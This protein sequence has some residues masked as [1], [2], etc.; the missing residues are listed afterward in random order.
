ME[1]ERVVAE[2]Q[3]LS[4]VLEKLRRE[5]SVCA[6]AQA[7]AE[8]DEQYNRILAERESVEAAERTATEERC[9]A[10]QHRNDQHRQQ[11]ERHEK[12]TAIAIA[13][14]QSAAEKHAVAL[15][16]LQAAEQRRITAELIAMQAMQEKQKVA[17]QREQTNLSVAQALAE[18][19]AIEQEQLSMAQEELVALR[20]CQD[21]IRKAAESRRQQL[22]LAKDRQA[23]AASIATAEHHRL[24]TQ[25]KAISGEPSPIRQ[26][27][28]DEALD[29]AKN[30]I[31]RL[32]R[33]GIDSDEWR[34]RANAV[35]AE[36]GVALS[37]PPIK[38][39]GPES[40]T[41]ESSKSQHHGYAVKPLPLSAKIGGAIA[42]IAFTGVA[43]TGIPAHQ[44]IVSIAGVAMQMATLSSTAQ[45][46][47]QR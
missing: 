30:L 12:A 45:A 37:Q 14:A 3:A 18:K 4:A 25:L 41:T 7:R 19:T 21:E 42:A 40:K 23:S 8:A 2:Q 13:A 34:A 16:A 31:E 43:L 32:T 9:R 15:A 10:E 44:K 11:A 20:S 35:L 46:G 17:L 1:R 24:A 38:V 33:N 47:T 36:T 39:S 6:A 26:W 22:L 27:N 28:H 5:Q 29:V